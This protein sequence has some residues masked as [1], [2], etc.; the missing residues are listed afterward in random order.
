MIINKIEEDKNYSTRTAHYYLS[1][2]LKWYH[3]KAPVKN[4]HQQPFQRQPASQWL[5]LL[6][7]PAL[8]GRAV[9]VVCG[10]WWYSILLPHHDHT[11]TTSSQATTTTH[12]SSRQAAAQPA[13]ERRTTIQPQSC[14][15]VPAI[16]HDS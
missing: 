10:R 12:N 11:T 4:I 5:R 3:N 8:A 15:A 16:A 2:R 13:N 6:L 1:C 14:S 7:R 9:V